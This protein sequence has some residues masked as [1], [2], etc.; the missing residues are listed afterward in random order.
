[1]TSAAESPAAQTEARLAV[2]PMEDSTG[3]GTVIRPDTVRAYAAAAG[4]DRVEV[5]PIEHDFRRFY[6]LV[7]TQKEE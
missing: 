2:G 7:P 3:T 1:M 6:R 5:L 4:L